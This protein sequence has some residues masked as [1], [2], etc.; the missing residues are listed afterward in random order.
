MK[1]RNRYL[2]VSV[3]LFALGGSPLVGAAS[4]EELAK[5]NDNLRKRIERLEASAETKGDS[6][7]VRQNYV[8]FNHAFAYEL[9]DPTTNINRKQ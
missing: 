4:V 9:L 6:S 3:A 5:E 8:R 1:E 2:G 7:E